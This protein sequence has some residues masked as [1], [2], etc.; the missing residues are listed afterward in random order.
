L[1]VGSSADL[2]KHLL[3]YCGLDTLAMVKVLEK[4]KEC[5]EENVR[6][7]WTDW[8]HKLGNLTLTGYNSD[9]GNNSFLAKKGEKGLSRALKLNDY[10]FEK[11]TWTKIEMKERTDALAADIMT[12]LKLE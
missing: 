8:V 11:D 5:V 10:F 1:K 3:A 9:M 12:Q 4:L 7:I 6:T 2:A